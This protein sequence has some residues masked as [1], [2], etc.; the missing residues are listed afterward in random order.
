[1]AQ[2]KPLSGLKIAFT[3]VDLEQSEHRGIA[4]FSKNLIA[5]LD[6]LGAEVYLLTGF[7]SY[8]IS[9]R[10]MREL[11]AGASQT[12]ILADILDRLNNPPESTIKDGHASRIFIDLKFLR[13]LKKLISAL[14]LLPSLLFIK[15]AMYV[16]LRQ[17]VVAQYTGG[18]R[19]TYIDAVK[20][21]ISISQCFGYMSFYAACNSFLAKPRFLIPAPDIDLVLT[22]CPLACGTFLTS[23]QSRV[24]V[25]Q[26][27]HDMFTLEYS[28]HPD[29]PYHFY[30]RLA[31]AAKSITLCVSRDTQ[32]KVSSILES[33][34]ETSRSYVL[35][36]PPSIDSVLLKQAAEQ[37]TNLDIQSP[38]I[39]FN[40]SVVQRK[41]VELLILAYLRS[42]LHELGV[43]LILAGKLHPGAYGRRIA[44]LAESC[45]LIKLLGYVS[46]F[47]KAWLYLN[48]SLL[49]SPSLSEGFGIPVLDAGALGVP[50]LASDIPS[51]REIANMSVL[52]ARIELVHGFD[53]DIWS[54]KLLERFPTQR[55]AQDSKEI[56]IQARIASYQRSAELI[57]SEF[58]RV[59]YKAIRQ[60][61]GI[62]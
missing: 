12:I 17:S 32:E 10:R 46:E 31:F 16:P 18:D 20:G 34:L 28:R 2:H 60:S 26:V 27:L 24:P 39:L 37:P 13:K 19:L 40:S 55:Y 30:N 54:S 29:N 51:H 43:Q 1:M 14:R 8:R 3:A 56:N 35:A 44:F 15:K 21:F 9:A 7:T 48:A 25:I 59:L 4:Y 62:S 47:D 38:F 36:Q 52:E 42:G 45:P 41:N 23:K 49:A 53:V 22:S 50:I 57:K 33:G 6:S 58:E 5:A 11:P 61:M